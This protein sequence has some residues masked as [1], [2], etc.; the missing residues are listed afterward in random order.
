[1]A[2]AVVGSVTL[3]GSSVVDFP[4]KRISPQEVAA[5]QRHEWKAERTAAIASVP[6]LKAGELRSRSNP[7]V[8]PYSVRTETPTLTKQAYVTSEDAGYIYGGA[9]YADNWS[10]DYQPVGIYSFEKNDGSTVNEAVVGEDYIVTGGGVFANGKYHYVSYMQFMGII[11]AQLYTVDFETW[12]VERSINVEPGSVAQDMAY[13]PTTGNAYGCFMN[14]NA[15]GWVF[16]YLNLETGERTML[17]NL[18]LV[19]LSVGVN[20]KG[21]VYGVGADGVFYKFDKHNGSRTTIGNTGRR[22]Y[23]SASGCFDMQT[24]VFYWEC[25]E[26]DN[27]ARLYTIDTQT[28]AATYITDIAHNMEMTGMFI[29]VADA[30]DDAP[31]RVQNLTP[32]FSGT[33]LTGNVTFTMPTKN[34][35]ETKTLSGNLTYEL[36][37]NE[38]SYKTATAAAGANVSVPVTV[39]SVGTYRFAVVAIN[40]VGRSPIVQ[41]ETWVGGDTPLAVDNLRLTRNA[42]TDEMKVTWTAPVGSVHNGYINPSEITY[43]VVRYPDGVSVASGLKATTFTEK[44]SSDNDFVLYEY[45]VTPSFNGSK[46]ASSR[47][48]QLGVGVCTV[49]YA[50][51]IDNATD[52]QAFSIEDTN[53]DGITWE[54]DAIT[55]MARCKYSSANSYTEPMNDWLFTPSI[56]L[57]PGH[58]Y[59]FSADLKSYDGYNERAE[60]GFGSEATSAA[61]TISMQ[62]V[63]VNNAEP[64]NFETYVSVPAEGKYYFGIHGCSPVDKLY[65]YADNIKVE[66]GPALGTP[67]RV[68]DLSILPGDKGE[69]KATISFKAPT[70]DVQGDNLTSITSIDIYRDNNKIHSV[71]NPTT[72]QSVTY[73]DSEARQSNNHYTI[74]CVNAKGEGYRVERDVYVGQDRPGLPLNVHAREENGKAVITWDAPDEGET[75]GYIDPASLTYTVLRA[76]D[77]KELAVGLTELTFTDANPPIGDARQGFFQYYVYAKSPAGYGYGQASNSLAV[78]EPYTLPFNESF[79]D[80]SIISGPWDLPDSDG[81]DATWKVEGEGTAPAC[82]SYDNDGGMVTFIP[83]DMNNS[84]KLVSSKISLPE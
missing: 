57:K 35:A 49:P 34:F 40:D 64:K 25:I 68:T 21:D 56:K 80:G 61:M 52:F 13:D 73:V 37:L 70:V 12:N 14:D 10:S 53:K 16:G 4:T 76:N 42:A 22:P 3:F 18:D 9:I 17:C 30:A 24:D 63:T 47:T 51:N 67:G 50:N 20:S 39:S 1:M 77:E 71:S 43:D 38:K 31:A 29:P 59:R 15:D 23:Y 55:S 65:L 54:Y 8:R 82:K 58:L 41:A 81:S 48:N 84:G 27:K 7:K 2:A 69:L 78:G 32:N 28:G 33:D 83:G 79:T 66:D 60:F 45:E 19:I 36:M 46:G 75:G 74:V 26:M 72:G 5:Q 44:I 62:P 11:L 6:R